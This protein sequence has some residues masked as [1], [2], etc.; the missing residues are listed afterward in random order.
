[1]I[2]LRPLEMCGFSIC[3][4]R[5]TDADGTSLPSSRLHDFALNVVPA[6]CILF[7]IPKP[8]MYQS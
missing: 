1:M 4:I 8:V 6:M 5:A 2:M 3:L 7:S